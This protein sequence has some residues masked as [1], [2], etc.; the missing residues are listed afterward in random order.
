VSPIRR[1]GTY[2][3]YIPKQKHGTVLRTT[4]TSDK[5]IYTL[6]RALVKRLKAERRWPLLMAVVDGTLTLGQLYDADRTKTLDTLEASLSAQ[7]LDDHMARYLDSCKARGLAP[8]NIE[9]IQRQLR[10][11]LAF[12][13]TGTTADLSNAVV[14]KWLATLE[15]SSGT[16][17]QFLYAVTGFTRYLVDVGVLAD[18]PL[19]RVKAPK[20]NAARMTYHDAATD[21]RIVQAASPKYRALFAF[22][23]GTGCDV[24]TALTVTARDINWKAATVRLRG[25]KTAKRDVHNALIEPWAMRYVETTSATIQHAPMWPGLSRFGAYQHHVRCCDAVGVEGYTLKDSRHSVAV[26]MAKAGYSVWEIAEQL[27]NSPELVARV[28]AAHLVKLTHKAPT[29]KT[30]GE[31]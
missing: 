12:A 23:K 20:K 21:E 5:R 1:K 22:I 17:R 31:M 4:G 16:R 3:L 9:N 28:Y 6:M 19:S 2:Y 15:T 10:A 25:T 13:P 11:F 27:G 26:R 29:A 14:T 8:R 24:T 18:Y 30:Q 7:R